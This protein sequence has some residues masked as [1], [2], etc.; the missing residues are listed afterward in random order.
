MSMISENPYRVLGVLSNASERELQKQKSKVSKYAKIGRVV[1]SEFDFNFLRSI[2]RTEDSVIK[3]SSMIEQNKDK[4]LHS[5]FWFID[6]TNI[7][8]TAISYLS[9]GDVDKAQEILFKVTD[10]KVITER[11]YSSFNNLATLFLLQGLPS[12]I[13]RGISIKLNLINSEYFRNFVSSVADQTYVINKTEERQSFVLSVI[14]MYSKKNY[15]ATKISSLFNHCNTD[16]KKYVSRYFSRKEIEIIEVRLSQLKV[17]RKQ[18][19]SVIYIDANASLSFFIQSLANVSRLIGSNSVDYKLLTDKV[20]L[21]IFQCGV[22]Y[23][24]Y[25]KD[26]NDVKKYA[27]PALNL[28]DYAKKIAVG[29]QAIERIDA[30]VSSLN[31]AIKVDKVKNYIS[32]I[33][34]KL[35]KID[36]TGVSLTVERAK[37]LF[38]VCTPYL[39]AIKGVVGKNDELYIYYQSMVVNI[40][41]GILVSIV[42]TAQD[43][44]TSNGDNLNKL[45]KIVSESVELLKSMWKNINECDSATKSRFNVN[46]KAI[47][48]MN[49]QLK[50]IRQRDAKEEKIKE[51]ILEIKRFISQSKSSSVID[52]RVLYNNCTPVLNKIESVLGSGDDFLV[53]CRSMVVNSVIGVVVSVVNQLQATSGFNKNRFN[54]FSKAVYDAAKFLNELTVNINKIDAETKARFSKNLQVINKMK[55]DIDAVETKIQRQTNTTSYS[56]RQSSSSSQ[57]SSDGACYV[58]TMAYGDYDHP[59]VMELRKFRDDI[60]KQSSLGRKFIAFYYRNSPKLVEKLKDHN[61]INKAIRKMLDLFVNIVK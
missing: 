31:E 1:E 34:E 3:A 28:M 7:D 24:Q 19:P 26:E 9:H 36:Q 55:S 12:N 13:E 60:L 29:S 18:T 53:Q 37:T 23:F 39:Q 4:V 48:E 30:N 11:N 58:A 33:D 49:E 43:D 50:E 10:G 14:E 45:A 57:S 59:Q 21:E 46:M 54:D 17:K 25:W 16:I 22:D 15:S 8:K 41:S 44:F 38:F 35:S 20:A 27:D 2:N 51:Y 52:A 42:N 5:L 40:V 56:S 32:A 61:R 47:S 6:V